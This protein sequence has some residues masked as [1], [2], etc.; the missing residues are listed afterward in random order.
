[1][2]QHDF[3][4]RRVFQ[5]RNMD[6]WRLDGSNRQI[7]GFL[8]EDQCREF[9][10]ELRSRWSGKVGHPVQ[11]GGDRSKDLAREIEQWNPRLRFLE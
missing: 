7:R 4:G 10:S 2:C 9:L 6:K 1:M 3:Q 5:H 8:F 11:M